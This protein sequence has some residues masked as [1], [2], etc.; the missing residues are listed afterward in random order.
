[1][2]GAELQ[3]PDEAL[4]LSVVRIKG[5][6][7]EP[8]GAG[9]LVAPDAVLTCAHV[10]AFALGLSDAK[11]VAVGASVT[12]DMPLDPD[13]A[14]P[15]WTAQV[16][17]CVAERDDGTGDVALLRLRA[18]VPGARSLPMVEPETAWD[19][20][21]GVVGFT[22]TAPGGIWVKAELSGPTGEGRRQFSRIGNTAYVE[23][24]FS[25]SPV[26]DPQHRAV[27]GIVS[28]AQSG[29][30]AQQAFAIRKD[31][32]VR[33]IPEL[34]SV[35]TPASPFLGLETFQE[36]HTHVYFGRKDDAEKVT[37]AL[38]NDSSV[39]VYGPSGS[40]K[41]SLAL[42]G[43]VPRMRADKYDVLVVNAGD[44][45]SL[46][47]AL[48][49]EMHE[50]FIIGRPHE[51]ARAQ[52]ASE[53]QA[54]LTELGLVDTLHRLRGKVGGKLLVVL[55]QAE[56]LLAQDDAEV[57]EVVSLLF[58][59]SP[60][61]TGL[62]VLLTLRADFMD[63]ALKHPH[64]GPAL[65]GGVTLPLTPM[66]REQLREVITKPLEQ[67]PGVA[68]ERGL[69]DRIL[70]D[71][72]SGPG[73]LPLLGFVLKMLWEN[74]EQGRL[75]LAT[76]EEA[77]GVSGALARHAEQAWLQCVGKYEN[78][79]KQEE[80]GEHEDTEAR[81]NRQKEA[82][83]RKLL[84]GLV[85]VLPGSQTPLRRRLTRLEAGDARW[86]IAHWFAEPEWRL[87]VMH[88]GHGEPETVELAHE[89]LV[90]VWPALQEQV[91]ADSEFLAGRAELAHERERWTKGN[92]ASGLLPGALQLAATEERLAS[93]EEELDED[94]RNFL[95]IARRHRKARRN[96]FRAAWT[97]TAVVLALIAGLG[98]FLVYQQH[99]ST[100]R[101]AESRSR[102]LANFSAEV[103]KQDPGQAALVAMAAHEI[104]PTDEAR[105][106]MLRRYDQFKGAAWVLT[107]AEGKIRDAVTSVDGTVTLVATDNGRATLFV[108]QAG[109]RT[110]RLQL[111]LDEMAFQPLVSRDGRRIAYVSAAGTFVWYGVDLTADKPE[112]LL[113]AAHTLRASEFKAIADRMN[114][115]SEDE[116]LMAF[117]PDARQLATM[118]DGRLRLWD[119]ATQR[120]QD[121]PGRMPTEHASVWFGP[122]ENTLV[123]R[124][125]DAKTGTTS[126]EAVEV[127]T[128][129]VRELAD[130]VDASSLH[131]SP[132]ALSGDGSV[133]VVCSQAKQGGETGA[134]YQALR[135]T[136]GRVL[137]SYTYTGPNSG[138]GTIAVDE[139][140]ERFA[141]NHYET[142]MIVGTR[143]DRRVRQAMAPSPAKTTGRL[144]GDPH[145]LLVLTVADGNVALTAQSLIPN[146]VEGSDI[147][148][149]APRLI[150][151][152]KTLVARVRRGYEPDS[153]ELL[154]LIDAASGR[155]TS[156]VKQP[157]SPA[158][159]K[160][161]AA[162]SLAVNDAGTLVADVV[163][164]DKILIRRI[165]SLRKVAEITTLTPP[166]NKNG[167]AEPLTLNFLRGGDELLTLA[168]SRIEHWNA[169]TGRRLSKA[170]D[171]RALKLGGKNP[172]R[173]GTTEAAFGSGFAVNSRPEAGYA[174]IMIYGDPVLHAINLRTGR[175]NKALRVRL[176][177]DV[178]R[179][180]LDNSGR[181][182]A[183]KTP[184]GMLE[185]WSAATGQ[186]PSRVVGPLGPLGSND[187]F[188]GDG[189]I[190]NFTGNNGEFYVA[191]GS[192]VRFQQLSDP[193]HFKTYD[194]A[195]NQ[196][197]V[198]ATKD[199]KT[200]LR[201]LSG[202]GFGESRGHGR[203][204]LIHLDP[205]LWK[206][207]LCDA[208]GRDLTQDERRG[209]P[210]GL[211][212][213]TCPA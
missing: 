141:A 116:S 154:A 44:V 179:A 28:V 64:L 175:E 31:S 114:W 4:V 24:G 101:Q 3:K 173:S 88:G 17:H 139:K 117:S 148:V 129:K 167:I 46:L 7:S 98:T 142:W 120:H 79:Q 158:P 53:V 65:R 128:G 156:A 145:H 72:D 74:K 67:V 200:L 113:T 70:D 130:N 18:A 206:R 68:Y 76:Y 125:A 6:D 212:D 169:R 78:A 25:G 147:V 57:A 91:R 118:A 61:A 127:G 124:H 181:Y 51:P 160:P 191:N 80:A 95:G 97:A 9:F 189:F 172:P 27:V 104:A 171:A 135:V 20:E 198:A 8:I 23:E 110:Q 109:G 11:Q 115:L 37:G 107:G 69:A 21:V 149:G 89:A 193:S 54:W 87:L 207:H 205:E 184:G 203:I 39:T 82:D 85:R 66:S 146:D 111:S 136:D 60:S 86:Q 176:G 84:T 49:T 81:R 162:N 83:A 204:D 174:Q 14:G 192:S 140:G 16:E 99:V 40:G 96:R 152:G 138:C 100:Q 153:A 166:V 35:L 15:N 71:A 190:F 143:H 165:P 185:L 58:P 132:T 105:N 112:G 103:A 188:T 50:A 209:M 186:R 102:L 119:L 93:R 2:T 56:A 75:R 182:A 52:S 197:F 164:R 48:A 59:A 202:G 168:G 77:G 177:R 26:W 33:E 55:D 163:D 194:F 29:R 144:L 122:D 133:L 43:V 151:G 13:L 170:I 196:Y 32:V 178:E 36:S 195:A 208:I 180:F 126:L 1:M 34:D 213:R 62:R 41:S 187:R 211:P 161:A 150:D 42:A 94:E 45:G 123:V 73:T 90:T 5:E 183:A 10:V 92:K 19:D 210:A 108:R 12:L 47:V 131:G 22:G 30:Q 155:I 199:G 134:T 63:A 121:V 137:N 201:T 38:A 106:A 157:E 159:P